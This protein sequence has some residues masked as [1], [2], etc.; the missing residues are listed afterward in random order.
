MLEVVLMV[1]IGK[2]FY[3]LAGEYSKNKW[4]Y[5]ISG[6]VSVYIG[7]IISGIIMALGVDIISPGSLDTVNETVLG[8]MVIPFALIL[9]WL[10]YR[11]LKSSWEKGKIIDN[12]DILDDELVGR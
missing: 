9:T 11:F 10:F 4:L 8:L 6:V 1:F 3:E 7:L 2:S 12:A 5:A